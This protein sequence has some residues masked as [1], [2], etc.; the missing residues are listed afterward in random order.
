MIVSCTDQGYILLIWLWGAV[1]LTLKITLV[2]QLNFESSPWHMA[3]LDTEM[4]ELGRSNQQNIHYTRSLARV[5]QV[6][7]S[8]FAHRRSFHDGRIHTHTHTHIHTHTYIY[9]HYGTI[10]SAMIILIIVLW[11]Q[12][13]QLKDVIFHW[14]KLK[15]S[16]HS[17]IL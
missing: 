10:I 8:H 14:K 12:T 11:L 3:F 2:L 6:C 4:K 15:E 17:L 9:K 16:M 13:H 5:P 1:E 7:L